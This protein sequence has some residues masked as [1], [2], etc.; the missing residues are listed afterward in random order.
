M[1]RRDAIDW[2]AKEIADTTE[3]QHQL[4]GNI[5]HELEDFGQEVRGRAWELYEARTK[6]P[7]AEEPACRECGEPCFLTAAGVAHHGEPDEID[8]DADARHVAIP[9]AEDDQ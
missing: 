4:D 3:A 1:T 9:E 5:D 7:A 8:Y 6:P 2:L